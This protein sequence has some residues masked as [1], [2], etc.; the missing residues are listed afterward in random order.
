MLPRAGLLRPCSQRRLSA[1]A[2]GNS[3]ADDLLHNPADRA[4]RDVASFP[5]RLAD[6]WRA[7]DAGFLAPVVGSGRTNLSPSGDRGGDD[8]SGV[9]GVG[10]DGSGDAGAGEVG[11]G[12]A[13]V[14]TG[15]GGAG[16]GLAEMLVDQEHGGVFGE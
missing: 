3:G 5:Y 1:V 15:A 4:K 12:V 16:A 2:V 9:G 11:E 8:D 14:A 10:P 13:D 6:R 7:I